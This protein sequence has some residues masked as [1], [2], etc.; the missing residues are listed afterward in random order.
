MSDDGGRHRGA[1]P[2]DQKLFAPKHHETLR[3]AVADLS[4]LRSRG[5]SS[6]ASLKL[7]GDHFALK[8]RQSKPISHLPSFIYSYPIFGGNVLVT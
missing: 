3:Q 5:Y 6:V 7:V 4:L 1:H 2:A 8:E